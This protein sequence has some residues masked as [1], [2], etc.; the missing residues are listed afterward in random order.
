M[1]RSRVDATQ[2]NYCA[3]GDRYARQVVAGQIPN[4]K[5]AKL[6]CQRQL[7][8]LERSKSDGYRWK[9]SVKHG[10]RVCK[11]I[12]NLPHVKGRWKTANI[13]LEPWQCFLLTVLFGWVDK[14]DELRRFKTGYI[15]VP[16][17]NAKTTIAAGI[18]LFMLCADG[19][20]G[21]EVYS[22]A[23]TKDQAR[24]SW[25]IAQQMVKHEAPMRDYYGLQALAHS[26]VIE[27]AGA[28]FK[29]LARDA[30]SLE[31]LNP[32]CA[33]I[34]ELHAHKTREV[35][36]VLNVARGSRRQS[37]LFAITTAGSDKTGVCYEQHDYVEQILSRR[38][39]DE[40]YFGVIYT[41]DA[42]DDWTAVGAARKANPNY[43]VSVLED[44]ITTIC[45]QAQRS[46]DSQNT[47]LTKRLNVW[48]SVGTA[49][50][51]MLA[52]QNR[53]RNDE[54]SITDFYGKSCFVGLDLASRVD[55]AAKITL[56]HERGKWQVFGRYYLPESCVERGHENYDVYVGWSKNPRINLTLTPGDQIDFEYI[57]KDLLEDRDRFQV[58]EVPYD[59]S[60][61]TELSTRME[62]EGLLMV[63]IP[64]NPS[65]LNE[66]MRALDGIIVS[67]GIV[68]D[69]DPVLEWM[70]GNVY[71]KRNFR[72]EVFPAKARNQNKIDGALALIM[73][74]SRASVAES[75]IIEYT[76][77]RSVG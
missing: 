39:E 18:A 12:E 27:T 16:R 50:F 63:P 2:R 38:H 70:L 47:Y 69:G 57:E 29:P 43:G 9:F 37:L 62:K 74:L 20:L 7:E 14:Q 55:I 60:Q 71:A 42:E 26:I 58:I 30:D 45:H 31:G 53:C 1:G 64:Q 46:A 34:D 10:N 35:W 40:R 48:V 28:A 54:L 5:W 15:E 49:Y 11:F 23:V 32:H 3:E 67:G 77:L 22:A 56:F 61:A 73:A 51:N 21:A 6:A 52:W 59:P 17:K 25:D 33:I 65:R 24:I 72:D 41:I 8:D 36:D 76:G 44:D 4:C 19:E 68:H 66:P 75:N 13:R